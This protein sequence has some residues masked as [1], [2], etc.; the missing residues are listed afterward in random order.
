MANRIYSVEEI[1]LQGWKK[2][3][4]IHPLTIKKLRKVF[5]ALD[6]ERDEIKEKPFIDVLLDAVAVAM[7]TFEPEL[8][9]SEVLADHVDQ[10]SLEHILEVAAGIKLNDPKLEMSMRANGMTT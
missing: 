7:E 4:K 8:S 10:L 6:F 9:D 1:E 5:E 3:I 2:P